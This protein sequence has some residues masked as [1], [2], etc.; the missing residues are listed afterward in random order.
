MASDS[1][2][3][4]G[5]DVLQIDEAYE[6]SAPR[7]FDFNN[8]ET[9]DEVRKAELWFETSLSYAPSPFMPRIKEGRSVKIDSVCDFGNVDMT[10]KESE[11]AETDVK[12]DKQMDAVDNTT[13]GK[14]LDIDPDN[15]G[16][17]QREVKD[18]KSSFE[19]VP[20]VKHCE[21]GRIVPSQCTGQTRDVPA[22]EF[23]VQSSSNEMEVPD[24]ETCTPKTKRASLKRLA[25]ASVR[26]QAVETCTPTTQQNP[27]N[28]AAAAISKHLTAKKI[29]SMVKQT[30][31]LKPKPKSPT[32]HSLKSTKPKSAIKCPS[33]IVGK[34][35]MATDVAQENQAIKR[36]KLDGGRSRQILNVKNRML[37]HKSRLG[38]PAGTDMLSSAA[39]GYQEDSHLLKEVIPFIS[40]AEMVKKFESRT[41]DVDI[42]Q[43]RSYTQ[44]D[45][46]SMIQR[47]PKLIL[48]RPKEPELQTAHRVRAV[49]VKSSAELEAEMLAKIP[50]FKARPFNK[51]IREAPS[52]PAL[53]RSTPQLPVFQEF[54]FKTIERASRHEET[55]S[56]ISSQDTSS[57]NNQSK[58]LKL[59]EPRP[60]QLET[61]LRARPSKVKSSQE[62]ELEEL[63]RAPRF[64]ARPLNKKILE[65][66]GDIGLVSHPKPQI[67]TPQE[68]HFATNDRLGAPA[69]SVADLFDKL[70]LHSESSSRYDKNE[71]PRITIPNP[72]HLHTEERGHEKER[73]LAMQLL[74]RQL[75]EEKARIPKASPYPYTT[76]YPVVPPKPEPKPC[77]RPEGF[78]LESLVRHEEEMQRKMEEKERMEREEAQKRLFRAQPILKE[79]PIPLPVKER[80]PLTEVQEFLL[81]VDHRSVQR[82]EFDKKM[83]EKEVKYKRLREESE[84]AKM[85]EEEKVV[86]QMRRTMVPHARPLPKFDNPFLP[87]RSAKEATKPKSPDLRVNHRG[88]RR[89]A[90]HMR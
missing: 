66:K 89:H 69:A 45:T 88:E 63:E 62:L 1:N 31:A 35:A 3:V 83:K 6:F 40:A 90:F 28:G 59:T 53:P 74:Q 44:D 56:V 78:Q 57:Q 60:P 8:E 39:K 36:Q 46:A 70:S 41:R 58:S 54:H 43:N 30:S 72:F 38:L 14:Q 26:N 82:S 27:D 55:S 49:R 33:S 61:A 80:K 75:E 16:G 67:T 12:G 37:P 2:G 68:F 25:P 5:V 73:Q 47:R 34:T 19:F 84:A 77:T 76:D 32:V 85:M 29:A 23:P 48:T 13:S 71:P 7:F 50:K 20:E 11:P 9:D 81:H 15:K 87:Q 22:F 86:K 64:K 52:L 24:S 51:K 79:D 18:G 4:G 10:Q 65:S 42:S 17:E 21:I